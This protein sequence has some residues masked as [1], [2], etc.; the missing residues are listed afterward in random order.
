MYIRAQGRGGLL[1]LM[2]VTSAEYL[3]FLLAAALLYWAARRRGVG[4]LAILGANCAFLVWQHP[5]YAF[6]LPAVAF[7]DF[8]IARQ[9]PEAPHRQKRFLA[10]VSVALNLSLILLTKVPHPILALSLSFYAFQAMTYTIDVCRGDA[11]PVDSFLRHATSVTFFPTLLAGPITNVPK[12]AAQWLKAR[13]LEEAEGSRAL[14]LIGLGFAK[15]FL[16]AD[17]LGEHLVNRV[18]DTPALYSGGENLLAAYGYAFQ[19]YYDFS[20]YTDIALGSALLVGIQLPANFQQPYAARNIAEFWR[21][22]HISF[23]TWLRDYLYY[24][25]PG[26]RTSYMP[27][28]GLVITMAL[29]GLWHGFSWNFL[30]WGLLHG[31][32]LAATRY[33]QSRRKGTA[34]STSLLG[35]TAATAGTFHLVLAGWI[36]FRSETTAGALT[37]LN[38]ISGFTMG[39]ANVETGF[40]AVLAAAVLLHYVPLHAAA[41]KAFSGAPAP[42]Q[43][44]ILLAILF[45]IHSVAGSAAAPFVYQKF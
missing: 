34:A 25:L 18:F 24:A 42:V 27:Y 5:L 9:I 4:L 10:G 22:W 31:T 29:G 28:L 20:G 41:Q 17:Y 1:F 40:L 11:R 45:S 19:L 7:A 39:F 15:K 35:R 3:C 36:F 16:I 21:R 30:I 6:L 12:L 13:D 8:S 44:A 43:A 38:Q 26:K 23:S 33:W 14:F 2:S 37:M 32:A